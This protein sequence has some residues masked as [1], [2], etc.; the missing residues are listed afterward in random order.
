MKR[1]RNFQN[2][3]SIFVYSNTRK[4][5]SIYAG[6]QKGLVKLFESGILICWNTCRQNW[7]SLRIVLTNSA[8]RFK[9][10]KLMNVSLKTTS[11]IGIW[12]KKK[13]LWIDWKK[14]EHTPIRKKKQEW[15]RNWFYNMKCFAFHRFFREYP[16]ESPV[17]FKFSVILWVYLLKLVLKI[18]LFWLEAFVYLWL[19]FILRR[20]CKTNYKIHNWI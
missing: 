13:Q 6:S 4:L 17:L 14:V 5:S 20:C 1:L 11:D 8:C 18:T 19:V 2:W 3:K 16:M 15:I 9:A 7:V 10:I 12:L